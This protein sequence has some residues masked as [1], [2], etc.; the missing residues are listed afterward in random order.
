[1]KSRVDDAIGELRG[2]E[3]DIGR[4]R[5]E[6]DERREP[7][8]GTIDALDFVAA[9][10]GS[11]A[12]DIGTPVDTVVSPPRDAAADMNQIFD[13]NVSGKLRDFN[14]AVA[15]N[16]L[17]TA[18]Q[19]EKDLCTIV[20][21]LGFLSEPFDILDSMLKPV[22]W[23]LDASD[24]VFD[25]VVSP[26]LDPILD[27]IGV[28]KL[29]DGIRD[30]LSGL[31][32]DIDVLNAFDK[33]GVL[34]DVLPD[35]QTQ[36]APD[37]G[38]GEFLDLEGPESFL[39]K[40]REA[41]DPTNFSNKNFV[42]GTDGDD[43]LG[44][45]SA[46]AVKQVISGGAGNDT[47]QGGGD[48]DIFRGGAGDDII[49][50]GG[51][52]TS[53]D[54]IVA[55]SGAI[56]EYLIEYSED[57][58]EVI[59]SHVDPAGLIGDGTDRIRNVE[60]FAF[61]GL[62]I[63]EE[64][65]R[66]GLQLLDEG[67]TDTVNGSAPTED[68]P[69]PR[70]FL[71]ASAAGDSET[72]T[73]IVLNGGK[74]D[75]HLIGTAYV[76]NLNGGAGNDVLDPGPNI[77]IG[78]NL[79]GGPGI[80]E[81][82]FAS[83]IRE[84]GER[85]DL[86]LA[87]GDRNDGLFLP[88]VT[89]NR[90]ERVEGSAFDDVIFG[91]ETQD[92]D[93][94]A[95]NGTYVERLAGGGGSDL[96]RGF[97]SDDRLVG[98]AGGDILI[99]DGGLN[100]YLGG[101][102]DDVLVL[103]P[104]AP[105]QQIDGGTGFDAMVYGSFPSIVSTF[106]SGV[107]GWTVESGRLSQINP[108]GQPGQGGYL[109]HSDDEPGVKDF[110]SAPR[111]TP[112]GEFLGNQAQMFGG[113]IS[114]DL[115]VSL[116]SGG[117]NTSSLGILLRGEGSLGI[118]GDIAFDKDPSVNWQTFEIALDDRGSWRTPTNT[119][120]LGGFADN[121]DIL[122]VLS[123]LTEVKVFADRVGGQEITRLD[124]FAMS[125]LPVK[126]PVLSQ[127]EGGTLEGWTAVLRS[128]KKLFGTESLGGPDDLVWQPSGGNAG[129]YM[130]VANT[131]DSP[132][133]VA[134]A[135][136]LGDQSDKMGGRIE[137]AIRQV[138]GGNL[139][140][141]ANRD[142]VALVGDGLQ[143]VADSTPPPDNGAWSREAVDLT[144]ANWSV[145]EDGGST[146]RDASEDELLSVLSD[147]DG[148]YIRGGF[149]AGTNTLGLDEVRLAPPSDGIAARALDVADQTFAADPVSSLSG[150]IDVNAADGTVTR[151]DGLASPIAETGKLSLTHAAQTV[152][153][154]R[155]YADPVVIA[156]VATENG[157]QPVNVRISE[158]EGA[159]LTLQL[160]EPK[161]LNGKHVGEAVNYM[162]V[163]AGSWVLPDGTILEAG[164]L[165]SD[166]LSSEGFEP[167]AFDAEFDRTPVILSQV[168]TFNGRDFVVTRQK[169]ADADGVRLTMQEEEAR[170][171]GN[172]VTE[173]LGWVALEAG[174]GSVGDVDWQAG[175]TS[176]IT[177]ATA[178]VGLGASMAGGANV[179]AGLSSFNGA[180]PAWA[181]G[182]GSDASSFDVSVEED[183][184]L[185][186]E[187]GH[188][189][190]TVDHFV[191]N[192]T[193]T[194]S[195]VPL[196]DVARD[197]FDGVEGIVGSA[198]GDTFNGVLEDAD[199]TIAMAGAAGDDTFTIGTG[200]QL[201]E[202]GPGADTVVV[203][204]RNFSRNE[205]YAGGVGLDTLDLSQVTDARW[206]LDVDGQLRGGDWTLSDAELQGT[207]SAKA[208]GFEQI[209]LGA[210]DDRVV[211]TAVS[212][213]AGAG[214]DHV[215]AG[216]VAG[217]VLTLGTGDDVVESF[218]PLGGQILLGLGN[219]TA[220]VSG[221]RDGAVMDVIGGPEVALDPEGEVLSD[222][223]VVLLGRGRV[224]VTG[225]DGQDIVSYALAELIDPS[226]P[227]TVDLS[228][229]T[230][231]A[232]G[233]AGLTQTG[234]ENA[235]GG[236]ANDIL[237]GDAAGNLLVGG[238]GDD[239]IEGEGVGVDPG[240]IDA[241][242]AGDV[243]YGNAG[244]DRLRGEV[245]EDVLHG[246]SGTNI[247]EGGPGKDTASFSFTQ[248][249]A[250]G[251]DG[252]VQTYDPALVARTTAKTGPSGAGEVSR[253][254]IL[255]HDDFERG[256]AGYVDS[257]QGRD[258]NFEA[259]FP[260]TGTI[261]GPLERS[262]ER[263]QLAQKT[264]DLGPDHAGPITVSFDFIEF[265]SW[266]G[267]E[268]ITATPA[269]DVKIAFTNGTPA[270]TSG[271]T[272]GVSWTVATDQDASADIGLGEEVEHQHRITL[273]FTPQDRS[274]PLAFGRE[275]GRPSEDRAGIDN[276]L[277]TAVPETDTLSDIENL[278][279]GALADVLV[280]NRFDNVLNGAAGDDTL[281]GGDGDDTLL[282]GDGRDVVMAG[283]GNDTVVAGQGSD[284]GQGDSY[285]GGA[286]F[287][288]LDYSGF[289][290]DVTIGSS[291]VKT[292]YQVERPVWAGATTE[293]EATETRKLED[294]KTYLPHD[295]AQALDPAL[296][297]SAD[298][299]FRDLSGIS[300]PEGLIET[301]VVDVTAIDSHV[302]FEAAVGT[303][304]D[305]FMDFL[306]GSLSRFEGGGGDDHVRGSYATGTTTA[307]FNGALAGYEVSGVLDGAV[308]VRDIDDSNGDEGTDTL[309]G[310]D[311]LEFADGT[312]SLSS[313]VGPSIAETGSNVLDHT[314]IRVNTQR[315][316]ET[317][318]V[319]A[320]VPTEDFLNSEDVDPLNVRVSDVDGTGF[321]LQLQEPNYLDG[322]T[323]GE[324]VTY[325][326]VEAGTHVLPDGTLLEAGTLESDKLSSQGFESVAFDAAFDG[327]PVALGQVQTDNGPDFV[328]TRQRDADAD[329]FEITMQEEELRNDGSHVSETLGWVAIEAGNGT[330]G[331][332]DWQAGSIA[333]VTEAVTTASLGA[334]MNDA[335]ALAALSS[336]NGPDPAWVSG[337]DPQNGRDGG[338][339]SPGLEISVEEDTSQD[340]EIRHNAETVD[341]FVFKEAGE[342]ASA[343]IRE[344]AET[345]TLS[346]DH[347]AT[348]VR[349]ERS[350]DDPVVI[351]HVATENG[352][353]PVNVRVSGVDGADLTL[354][355]QEPNYLDGA[356]V[357]ETVNY[358]VVEAGTWV[359]SDGTLLEAGTLASDKISSE[360]F[361]SVAFNA[362]FDSA[363]AML[364][365]VQSFNG[366]DFVSTR[367]QSADTDGFE[368]TMQE[369]EALNDGNHVT[370]TLGWVALEAGSGSV[371]DVDWQAGS[372]SGITD[373]TATVGLG[374]SM[375]SRAN[376][377][378]ALSSYNGK[379]SAWARGD[380]ATDAAFDVSVEEDTSQDAETR[381]TT[382]TVDY[383]V[384]HSEGILEAYDYDFFV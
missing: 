316:Y 111:S 337:N 39:A 260:G 262:F 366:S 199:A 35:L 175:S 33:N 45:A 296:A 15:D 51:D 368:V 254:Q 375:G 27:A 17:R 8:Q 11:L 112:P 30:T 346:L 252:V 278:T 14:E 205:R 52:A 212:V 154:E 271:T 178:T 289:G 361:E 357:S 162:V 72:Q 224:D 62:Q 382:E 124:N 275:R 377:I 129:A 48:R 147:L 308:T 213:A 59:V 236:G 18:Q 80:D 233:A 208:R 256:V 7:V 86:G 28:N 82:A 328:T 251:R 225:G 55:F 102:G 104:T 176:G 113:R 307:V 381:H 272:S 131:F 367:Q 159:D 107:E 227:V 302:G 211:T 196:E 123:N 223:D 143:L 85:L 115:N 108:G 89:V 24:F 183:T 285:D 290:S 373:A 195:A 84:E 326:V 70:D 376:A 105:G 319:I 313:L 218:S 98:G 277:I 230:Q 166:K 50:G 312:R 201:V 126:E 194:L 340:A 364:S 65:L 141:F 269:G 189:A 2:L 130:E 242:E 90:I 235:S 67:E 249:N 263:L 384:F 268:L 96:L 369:E 73:G 151:F 135:S 301:E 323:A 177:D 71:I 140:A 379:D 79:N 322:A 244:D 116:V 47:L 338:P 56:G 21:Q 97:G 6:F 60:T 19:M 46:A 239:T 57:G 234:V 76:D 53:G 43:N 305:D 10:D 23:A 380:G 146:L 362:A 22:R 95:A 217:Q 188:I 206:R 87:S 132:W 318:V 209:L 274:V 20:D 40:A 200:R 127:F 198:Q 378:A 101:T 311:M 216:N 155:S 91:R 273:T 173:T 241:G 190:E 374:A 333:G 134:P 240:A 44:D 66:N 5:A 221:G 164:T 232:D 187:T 343:P 222:D 161:H 34:K 158:V 83:S 120:G 325:M 293:E 351:A 58:D 363:P 109:R 63:T 282:D 210:Y 119:E 345:G 324:L 276:L 94:D 335:Y 283:A 359:L 360:G 350:Y 110:L 299:F 99:G 167:V 75:D 165:R 288:V 330:A 248:V 339:P 61:T 253:T 220:L 117:F 365:Q 191:F 38:L 246:G 37:V 341:Y 36:L 294:G 310:I 331:E 371:G 192:T 243:L 114:F 352:P 121:A 150:R 152:T 349:L 261:L 32:P 321:T 153:L 297:D 358:L 193:G 13:A 92:I 168:Q 336:F 295:I 314:G 180:Q 12:D 229:N 267:T 42:T 215:S 172:H 287:D 169:R 160:Q 355:L 149:K 298:D 317:P 49:D 320:F 157:A 280:G 332:V 197:S 77:A 106:D 203:T 334:G 78:D 291:S 1:M 69:E 26:V 202:A 356:H 329:G 370:E 181:R 68:N 170:N 304:F 348:T 29:F 284:D 148:L 237:R 156:H 184:S 4:K 292:S 179:I 186:A 54:D 300:D 327:A 93:G 163:E 214:N 286:G 122:G 247:L 255:H 144:A 9:F 344:I 265:D 133:F 250:V 100:Q 353:Q 354:Q 372:T 257:W 136:Y 125:A 64:N 228:D 281:D 259:T 266:D 145:M 103:D 245:G 81:V 137:Y 128:D 171:D 88:T 25:T 226:T 138:T 306:S 315:S 270:A 3:A 204:D 219:D 347:T 279:G 258:F 207:L 238:D 383:F 142:E 309:V 16:P 342:I 139:D 264:F 231:N 185:D 303:A 74:G 31:L 174:S 118:V 182:D 41:I